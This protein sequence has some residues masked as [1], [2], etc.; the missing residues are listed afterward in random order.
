MIDDDLQN[1]N[2]DSYYLWHFA[3]GQHDDEYP[4]FD[5][6]PFS[7]D[8]KWQDVRGKIMEVSVL[9][10]GVLRNQIFDDSATLASR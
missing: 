5:G 6:L 4:R 7:W 10:T 3:A 9:L 2:E 8:P 1:F